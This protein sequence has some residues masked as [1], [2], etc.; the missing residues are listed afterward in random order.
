M[1]IPFRLELLQAWIVATPILLLPVWLGKITLINIAQPIRTSSHQRPIDIV[2]ELTFS[3]NE[4]SIGVLVG[5]VD[6]GDGE[7]RSIT[8]AGVYGVVDVGS[9][10]AWSDDV[11]DDASVATTISSNDVVPSLS[12]ILLRE[13]AS[14]NERV[15]S[16]SFVLEKVDVEVKECLVLPDLCGILDVLTP[17][18]VVEGLK[19]LID[20]G[21]VHVGTDE[22][23]NVEETAE[24][25]VV[26]KH[27]ILDPAIGEVMEC[28][29][30][31]PAVLDVEAIEGE[32]NAGCRYFRECLDGD[33][34]DDGECGGSTTFE[35]PEEVR[36]LDSIGCAEDA[37]CSDDFE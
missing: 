36:I 34:D 14:P 7:G 12:D 18:L 33:R 17:E 19:N 21:R 6:R 13:D 20:L 25:L 27:P 28:T 23:P 31:F 35:S 29:K 16:G 32:D 11:P 8:P 22:W 3:L 9:S 2:S 1:W 15:G 24:H 26:D 4:L 37:I 10:K 5:Q 30:C